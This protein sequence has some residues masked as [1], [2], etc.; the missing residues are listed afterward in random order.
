MILFL[1]SNFL[2]ST[3]RFQLA[4]V[5]S[6][7]FHVANAFI[8][9]FISQYAAF[10]ENSQSWQRHSIKTNSYM[11][12]SCWCHMSA[13]MR[14]RM[15]LWHGKYAEY[16]CELRLQTSW[17]TTCNTKKSMSVYGIKEKHKKKEERRRRRTKNYTI[18]SVWGVVMKCAVCVLHWWSDEE[19]IYVCENIVYWK[20]KLWR[21]K[22]TK[23][24]LI[25]VVV[26]L[27]HSL[28][29]AWTVCL[30]SMC[31]CITVIATQPSQCLN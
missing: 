7:N 5:N 18:P 20:S 1:R 4:C 23:I 13:R 31:A 15:C 14:C 9:H 11:C 30:I 27:S 26:V 16:V 25:A 24:S 6:I 17:R 10:G 22:R 28:W 8:Q 2:D 19:K 3:V 21:K 29:Y 12:I